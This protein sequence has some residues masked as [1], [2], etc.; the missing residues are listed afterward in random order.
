MVATRVVIWLDQQ[1]RAEIKQTTTY[2][3]RDRGPR[4]ETELTEEY[5]KVGEAWLLDNTRGRTK[6]KTGLMEYF[7]GEIDTRRYDYKRFTV[8]SRVV[9][10]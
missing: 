7:Y 5:S 1:D 8:D 2:E 3:S 9:T 6:I 10:P 4:L